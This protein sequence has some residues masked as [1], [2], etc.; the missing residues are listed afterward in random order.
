MRAPA[1]EAWKVVICAR[2]I[3]RAEGA[4][5]TVAYICKRGF[6]L[7]DTAAC[8]AF[9]RTLTGEQIAAAIESH[10]ADRL[11]SVQSAIGKGT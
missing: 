4:L 9:L 7:N 2:D 1:D 5:S 11:A 8:L 10:I 3:Q 6:G